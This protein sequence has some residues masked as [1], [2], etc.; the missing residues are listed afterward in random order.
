M[1]KLIRSRLRLTPERRRRLVS[2]AA[3]LSFLGACIFMAFWS[4]KE[5]VAS[6]IDRGRPF[7]ADIYALVTAPDGSI[8]AAGKY[9]NTARWNGES[10]KY[11][12]KWPYSE[13]IKALGV[14]QDGSIWAGGISGYT[15]RWNGSWEAKGRALGDNIYALTV[16][17]DGSVWVAGFTG[18]V[19][20]WNG[21]TW[22]NM[23]QWPHP[24]T[25][26]NALV[27]GLNGYIW[28]GGASGC[29]AYWNG[30]AWVNTGQV[31]QP[32]YA[33]TVAPDGSI[34]AAGSLG[35]VHRWNGTA[36][37]S[38]GPWINNNPI[39]ALTAAQDGSVW[40]ADGYGSVGRWNGSAW[41]NMGTWPAGLQ[42]IY[43]MTAAPDGTI[44]VAGAAGYTAQY[45]PVDVGTPQLLVTQEGP[46]VILTWTAAQG[47]D[48]YEVQRSTDGSNYTRICETA[49][50]TY[51]DTLTGQGTFYYRVRGKTSLGFAGAFSNV[52]CVTYNPPPPP[53][54]PEPATLTAFWVD[55]KIRVEWD[56]GDDPPPGG[57]VEL[58][59]QSSGSSAWLPV[60]T[61]T[62]AEK[63]S[64]V[65]DDLTTL[66]GLNYQ[67]QLR[68]LG[69]LESDYNWQVIAES[70]WA[71]GDRPM[72]APGGLRVSLG[73][74]SATVTWEAVSGANSYTVQYS[75][76]RGT[77]W[78]TFSV[79]S[80]SATVP[81]QCMARVRAGSHSRSQWSGIVAVP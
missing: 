23:G 46:N 12:G 53:P 5:A 7:S 41:E 19:A 69:S 64:F 50:T 34:W 65:W 75:T 3:I 38:R 59:R 24:S 51:T 1:V 13:D 6:W 21:S 78:Q 28:A 25:T 20:R 14:S 61:L 67:Y 42:A 43:A 49:Q 66:A 47:A 71:T 63:T 4:E 60:K 39:Y 54:P 32:V 72:A 22:E 56:T 62:D 29:T 81:R 33:L 55:G 17:Q 52:V 16:A 79:S 48:L 27:T 2:W 10:W 57:T 45:A 30:S 80:T 70:G 26:I 18:D 35:S 31:S 37:E 76:D 15:A 36:W 44:W 8:W 40:A 73:Q 11:M 77:T 58:V 74:T 9:G 68:S